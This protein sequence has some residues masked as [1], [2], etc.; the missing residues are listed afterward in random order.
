VPGAYDDGDASGGQRWQYVTSAFSDYVW[1]R[2][3]RYV[4][5]GRNNGAEARSYDMEA[6][7]QQLDDIAAAKGEVG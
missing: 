5:M 4:Y 7:P 3:D 6:D 1:C 2:N